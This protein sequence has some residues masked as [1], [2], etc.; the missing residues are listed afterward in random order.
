[1]NQYTSVI[2]NGSQ[3]DFSYR[4]DANLAQ[5][6]YNNS[7]Y[8]YDAQSRLTGATVNGVPMTFKYD[9][10]NRQVGRIYNGTTTFSV[11]DG[12]DL[13]E[14]YQ[15]GGT[16]TTAYVYGAGGLIAG[17]YSGQVYYYYQD[18]SGSTSHLTDSNGVLK[19]WY[20]Y[21]LQGN[22]FFYDAN[23]N[24]RNPNQSSFGV[25]HLFTGQQWYKELGL[26]DL[27]N[28]FYSPD[29]GRFLQPDPIGLN[30]D[31]TNLYR[32][33]GNNP[34]TRFDPTGLYLSMQGFGVNGAT[35]F[36][37]AGS[38]QYGYTINGW[39]PLNWTVGYAGT[40]SAFGSSYEGAGISY[41]RTE[42]FA[43]SFADLDGLSSDLGVSATPAVPFVAVGGQVG[44][45]NGFDPKP[46]TFSSSLT[47]QTPYEKGYPVGGFVGGSYTFTG[48]I[49]LGSI[50]SGIAHLF[51][52]LFS[53]GTQ[54]YEN[55]D[56]GPPDNNPNRVIVRGSP[57]M[58]GDPVNGS[59]GI[60]DGSWPG[61]Y[62]PSGSTTLSN[63]YGSWGAPSGGP[64]G[65]YIGPNGQIMS[66][67]IFGPGNSYSGL[68]AVAAF[69]SGASSAGQNHANGIP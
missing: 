8:N 16:M 11:W 3:Y 64:I 30:G 60:R 27:R 68:D 66:T 63:P 4:A 35:F 6:D 15:S 55:T 67:S 13:V 17:T 19:E 2:I 14:E 29:V 22:P 31:P 36:G 52:D 24:Q 50:L 23:N 53:S 20:R 62:T 45:I 5:Y 28:R 69:G 21:D 18:G 25:R 9:G 61:F 39:N 38:F 47:L 49:S 41:I 65:N 26:Y 33:C 1:L 12:W 43:N 37:L 32:Y 10:L 58:P 34:V 59:G 54:V 57:I 40:L 44:N 48:E 7:T 46:L 51:Q 56:M 42:S